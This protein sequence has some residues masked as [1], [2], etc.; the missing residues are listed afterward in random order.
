M[1]MEEDILNGAPNVAV[2]VPMLRARLRDLPKF[3]EIIAQDLTDQEYLENILRAMNDFNLRPPFISNYAAYDFPDRY[4][5]LD[6]AVYESLQQLYM[7]H[8]RNQFS[9]SDAG[10]EVPI[11]EQ[12]QPLMQIAENMRAKLDLR[13]DRL[14]TQI[15]IAQALGGAGVSSPLWLR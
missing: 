11:H 7:W 1:G 8:A 13:M 2:H 12:W 15:N 14:K 3:N 5:L 10:L 6:A 9:A 4:M